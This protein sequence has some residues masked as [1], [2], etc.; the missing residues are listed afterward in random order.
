LIFQFV[1]INF[2]ILSAMNDNQSSPTYGN[3]FR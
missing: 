1:S 2:S 3:N